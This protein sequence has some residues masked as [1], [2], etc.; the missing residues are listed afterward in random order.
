MGNS[1]PNSSTNQSPNLG[2]NLRSLA[3]SKNGRRLLFFL[4]YIGE[5][6]PIG[7][8]W[9]ALP[10]LMSSAGVG[11][12]QIAE[13]G[14]IVVLPWAMKL[15][16]APLVDILQFPKWT[17]RHWIIICQIGMGCTLLPLANLDWASDFNLIR[18]LLIAH[19]IFAATQDVSIDAW[20]IR[21][22]NADEHG[23]INGFMQMGMLTGRW[24]FASGYLLLSS[25]FPQSTLVYCLVAVIWLTS[26][27]VLL[28]P[29]SKLI[30]HTTASIKSSF[31]NFNKLLFKVLKSRV[32]WA[33]LTFAALAGCGYHAATAVLGDYFLKRGLTETDVANF[34]SVNIV[35]LF[36]GS[37][38]GG[39]IADR[40]GHR[41]T[42]AVFLVLMSITVLFISYFD[43]FTGSSADTTIYYLFQLLHLEIG[44]F[45]AAS[46]GLLMDITDKQLG[47]TQ[48]SAFMGAVNICE[49][50]SAFG[51]ARAFEKT[52]S[53]AISFGIF[54]LVSL[55]ALLVLPFLRKPKI[56]I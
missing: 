27:A 2:Q 35:G 1:G 14:A 47:A 54:A 45:V 20:A 52:N 30:V 53:Y 33:G 22:T 5:G 15:F 34:Y 29:D 17:L 19:A 49:S 6:A 8:I 50:W 51:F 41:K 55:A 39:F 24:L 48:Y 12:V 13:L 56:L 3:N 9:W 25:V 46:Y 23:T 38:L 36:I 11:T 32:T 44:L 43:H 40:F 4:L 10:T 26:F 21:S 28:N 37:Y 42:S 18:S 16:W 31:I 7:F